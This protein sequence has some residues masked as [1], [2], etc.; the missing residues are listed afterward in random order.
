MD[1]IARLYLL[2]FTREDCPHHAQDLPDGMRDG[3]EDC[4]FYEGDCD[5]I[6][7]EMVEALEQKKD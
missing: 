6:C 4:C 7:Q 2:D 3:E 5:G 1:K